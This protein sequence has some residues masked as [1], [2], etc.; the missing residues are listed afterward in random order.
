MSFDTGFNRQEV[1][2][3]GAFAAGTLAAV[4]A[5]AQSIAIAALAATLLGASFE[6][7]QNFALLT[8]YPNQ[9][10]KLV[11]SAMSTYVQSAPPNDTTKMTN[12]ETALFF[13]SGMQP[14][15]LMPVSV[16]SLLK[17][18]KRLSLLIRQK[19]KGPRLLPRCLLPRRLLP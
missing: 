10:H 14:Y 4:K 2:L 18:Y 3:A 17:P 7:F 6:N 16:I 8:P 19:A 11:Q 12:V 9:V 1:I 13:V 15:A 5:S